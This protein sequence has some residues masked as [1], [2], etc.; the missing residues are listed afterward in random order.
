VFLHPSSANYTN[1]SY[2]ERKRELVKKDIEGMRAIH[3]TLTAF[4]QNS[5]DSPWM[6]YLSMMAT[7]KTWVYDAT[8]VGCCLRL[9]PQL[10]LIPFALL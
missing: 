3:G 5:Y 7:G 2:N 9:V 8:M 6:V 10:S 1:V 4:C